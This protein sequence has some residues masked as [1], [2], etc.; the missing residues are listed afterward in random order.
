MTVSMSLTDAVKSSIGGSLTD[1]VKKVASKAARERRVDLVANSSS[2]K[3]LV[4]CLDT[5]VLAKAEPGVVNEQ[6][7]NG[8]QPN[9]SPIASGTTAPKRIF[10][11][12]GHDEA[13]KMSV[14]RFLEQMAFE[15]IV[16]NEQS[17]QGRT[18]IEKIEAFR[19]VGFAVVLLTPDDD[20]SAE[21]KQTQR[22]RQNV[23]LELGYFTAFLG[24]SKVCVLRKGNAELPS[25]MLGVGWIEFDMRGAWKIDVAKELKEAGYAIT[26]FPL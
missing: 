11:V 15:P 13:A 10:V 6:K 8:S 25:D 2:V 23:I 22:A 19:D 7:H 9:S 4:A 18:I 1:A 17:N 24:R 14:A 26:S 20:C 12:H 5:P 16:L 21:G 3:L